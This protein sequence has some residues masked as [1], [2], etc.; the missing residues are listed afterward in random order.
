MR[1]ID[2]DEPRAARIRFKDKLAFL[3][4]QAALD[5]RF[6]A[7]RQGWFEYRPLIRI[8]SPLH[9]GLTQTVGT[10]NHDRVPEARFGIKG[11]DDAGDADIGANHLLNTH[12]QGDTHVFE[13][14]A[15]SVVDGPVREEGRVAVVHG[16][17]KL[18]FPTY[19]EER[20]VLS[21]E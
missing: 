20:A 6:V 18:L 3:G 12:R 14:V 16:D 11:K 15:N 21:G 7:G 2:R 5:D 1:G 13:A 17:Q 19:I 9:D 4:A 10:G 8:H